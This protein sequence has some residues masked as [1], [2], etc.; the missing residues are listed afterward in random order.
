MLSPRFTAAAWLAALAAGAVHPAAAQSTRAAYLAMFDQDGDGRVSQGEY[1]D[2][3][4]RGFRAMDTNHDDVLEPAELP[5]GRGR[6]T[7]LAQHETHLRA[8]FGKLDRN[9][10]GTLDA[11]ELTQPPQ[12]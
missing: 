4:D 7:T 8:Q 5:G 11:R 12:P 2:H 1:V 10:D 3:M 9:H 6:R